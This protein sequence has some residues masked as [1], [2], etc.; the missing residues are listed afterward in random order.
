MRDRDDTVGT[1]LISLLLGYGFFASEPLALALTKNLPV[2][3]TFELQ[4]IYL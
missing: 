1:F 3:C 2:P 4:L